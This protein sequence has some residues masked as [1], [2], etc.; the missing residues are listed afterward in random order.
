[1]KP[2][3]GQE[4]QH[5]QF[6]DGKSWCNLPKTEKNNAK[7]IYSSIEYLS[8][9]DRKNCHPDGCFI[10]PRCRKNHYIVDNYD[11]LCDGCVTV[12]L[13]NN[14]H[15]EKEILAW[16]EKSKRHWSGNPQS[17][18]AERIQLRNELE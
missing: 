3:Y 18:I 16:K 14:S 2:Y 17:E 7:L 12:E 9:L 15:V 13:G 4:N 11:L 6:W 5:E 8:Q 10:C 1:M